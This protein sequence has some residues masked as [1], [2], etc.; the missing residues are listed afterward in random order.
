MAK[1][2]GPGPDRGFWVEAYGLI[3]A[4]N[5]SMARFHLKKSPLWEVSVWRADRSLNYR[6]QP[7]RAAT[8]SSLEENLREI[9]R[10][11]RLLNKLSPKQIKAGGL[12]TSGFSQNLLGHHTSTSTGQRCSSN[13]TC[14]VAW[15]WGELFS[16]GSW[17]SSWWAFGD[18]TGFPDPFPL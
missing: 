10:S 14:C 11:R 7:P 5:K 3:T 2:T 13:L 17:G 1:E 8:E 16:L 18:S 6:K 12:T 9:R 4:N 15:W